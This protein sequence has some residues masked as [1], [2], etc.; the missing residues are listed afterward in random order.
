MEE[1]KKEKQG[2]LSLEMV[3]NAEEPNAKPDTT[4]RTKK[5]QQLTTHTH[6]HGLRT[7]Q[8]LT[9]RSFTDNMHGCARTCVHGWWGWVNCTWMWARAHIYL[10]MWFNFL[11]QLLRSKIKLKTNRRLKWIKKKMYLFTLL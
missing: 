5:T 1:K 9:T 4:S 11:V 8:N 7:S 2:W 10:E 6:T 3:G